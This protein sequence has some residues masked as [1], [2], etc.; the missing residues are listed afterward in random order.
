[1]SN[2]AKKRKAA[3]DP[4]RQWGMKPEA[5]SNSTTYVVSGH[6][7]GGYTST[8]ETMGREAQAKAQR[9]KMKQDDKMLK[10]LLDRDKDGM[11]TVIKA[12]E[13]MEQQK[14]KEREKEKGHKGKGK[15]KEKEKE[16]APKK[17]MLETTKAVKNSFSAE[18]VK[19][20]GF[21]PTAKPGQRREDTDV[22]LKT[23]VGD[24]KVN[25]VLF[26]LTTASSTRSRSCNYPGRM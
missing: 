10:S 17:S 6:I 9:V 2:H 26:G 3:Y 15:G 18:V 13:F 4:A 14:E 20:L 11:K 25:P 16:A 7:V 24:F 22:K 23:K 1:M 12:R 19:Q 21:D 8:A 5:E